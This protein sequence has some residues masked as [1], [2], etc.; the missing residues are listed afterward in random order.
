[1]FKNY[2]SKNGYDEY[3]LQWFL[4]L[5]LWRGFD[6]RGSGLINRNYIALAS[7]SLS[8]LVAQVRGIFVAASKLKSELK[9]N[10]EIT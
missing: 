10:I 8:K 4:Y 7:S 6:P 3:F 5:F 1:M 2:Q 9:L